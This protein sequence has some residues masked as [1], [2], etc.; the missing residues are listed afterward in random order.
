MLAM[1]K[2][3]ADTGQMDGQTRTDGRTDEVN[4]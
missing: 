4:Q 1:V 2:L 3:K